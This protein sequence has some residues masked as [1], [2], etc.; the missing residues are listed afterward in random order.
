ML[1]AHAVTQ[2]DAINTQLSAYS[3]VAY[4]YVTTP[5]QW[6]LP[7]RCATKHQA[8]RLYESSA[9]TYVYSQPEAHLFLGNG[10]GSPYEDCEGIHTH[11][12]GHREQDGS[13]DLHCVVGTL[14]QFT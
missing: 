1:T 7:I 2:P 14:H 4:V 9:G 12:N 10:F 8:S 6:S 3:T 13:D 11:H 5:V